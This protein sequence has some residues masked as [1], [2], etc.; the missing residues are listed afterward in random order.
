ME[1]PRNEPVMT[2]LGDELIKT[3]WDLL[4]QGSPIL[5]LERAEGALRSFRPAADSSLAGRLFLVIGVSL[6]A[7]GRREA[8]SRYF[9]DASWALEMSRQEF[10]P[11]RLPVP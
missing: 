7:L 11:D 3:C 8:A 9:Q 4:T 5:A 10:E 1:S 6:E 2:Q